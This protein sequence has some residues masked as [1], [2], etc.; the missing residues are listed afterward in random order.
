[1]AAK[2]FREWWKTQG[3]G[4]Y[5]IDM[6]SAEIGWSAANRVV[7]DKPAP[8]TARAEI[9][10]HYFEDTDGIHVVVVG[11]CNCRGKLSPIA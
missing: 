6:V 2:T 9:C 3:P 7:V 4:D 1:M 10:P 8:N 5:Q 11:Q